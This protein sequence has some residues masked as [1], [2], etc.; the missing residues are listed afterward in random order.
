MTD[1]EIVTITVTPA[2]AEVRRIRYR[3]FLGTLQ[4]QLLILLLLIGVVIA[5]VLYTTTKSWIGA[6]AMIAVWAFIVVE[7]FGR[8][9][10]VLIN[11]ASLRRKDLPAF[12]DFATSG[13]RFRS[14]RG[15]M[16]IA[17][18]SVKRVLEFPEGYVFYYQRRSFYVSKSW[19]PD[20]WSKA[21]LSTLIQEAIA[22]TRPL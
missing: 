21:R 16:K 4:G 22:L 11:N 19:L 15:E 18:P 3:L 9:V 10:T 12:Y 13:I 2:P 1:A 5:L 7:K 8:T 14:P 6:A 17:W 20:A